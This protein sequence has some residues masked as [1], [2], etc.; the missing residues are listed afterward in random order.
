MRKK[1]R[2][3]CVDDHEAVLEGLRSRLGL[4][5]DFEVVGQ[6]RSADDLPRETKRRR[7]GLVLLDV[8]MPGTDPF[9]AASDLRAQFPDVRVV[10]LTA[11]LRDQYLD[12]AFRAGAWGYLFK[13]DSLDEIVDA[14]RRASAGEFVISPR[15]LDP[16]R[17]DPAG[18][19]PRGGRSKLQELTAREIQVLQLIGRGLSRRQ[20]AE[21]VHRSVKTV[22]THRANI[23][24]KLGIHDRTELALYAIREG[25]VDLDS[26]DGTR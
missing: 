8:A 15:L 21:T 10:F 7:P 19:K 13:G 9:E 1:V 22:D 6:L 3:L 25:L 17:G 14:L 18:R 12:A 20:I 26:I 5:P 2:L 24:K 16:R 4:E 23:M 11:Y